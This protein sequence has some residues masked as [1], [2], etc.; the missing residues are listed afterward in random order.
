MSAG[1]TILTRPL[2][3]A[4]GAELSGA[5][6]SRPL[7]DAIYAR[8]HEAF[9]A[10]QLLLFRDQDLPPLRQV[11]LGRRFGEVQVHVMSQYHAHGFPELYFLSNLDASGNPS[12]AH[13]DK[14]TLA[15]HTDGSWRRVTGQATIMYAEEVPAEGGDTEFCDMYGAYDALDEAMKAR[16]AGLRAVHNLDFSRSR[17]HGE[18]PMTEAQKRE[19]PPVDHPIVRTHPETGRKCIFLGDHAETVLGLDYAEGRGLVDEVNAL[20]VRPELTYRHRW[21]PG[22]LVIWDNRCLMHRA[23]PYDTSKE[24]RVMRRCTILGEVPR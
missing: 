18:D 20:A 4:F 8:I 7:D 16:L 13:P 17:R 24:R 21:R 19:V 15:W 22:D 3:A 5:D 12:G 23:M 9:I 1:T 11:E 14:G 10:Y 2:C 6:L